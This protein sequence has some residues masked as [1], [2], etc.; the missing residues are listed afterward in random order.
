MPPAPSPQ[1]AKNEQSTTN[2]WRGL[3]ESKPIPFFCVGNNTSN[4]PCSAAGTEIKSATG[5][6]L[7]HD[8][9]ASNLDPTWFVPLFIIGWC[10]VL[11]FLS[12]VGGWYGLSQQ[13]PDQRRMREKTYRFASMGLGR[14]YFPVSYGYCI[15]VHVDAEGLAVSVLLPFRI[16]HPPFFIPW[17]AIA[18]C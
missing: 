13:Y 8:S 6:A 10:T 12:F 15:S 9:P 11:A 7:M 4:L 18:E 1:Q 16:F 5:P 14:G 3:A 17:S 2:G